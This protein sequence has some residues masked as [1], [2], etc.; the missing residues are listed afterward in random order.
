[1]DI[2]I[3][4]ENI[5]ACPRYAGVLIKGLTVTERPELLQNKLRLI[6][7]RPDNDILDLTNYFLHAKRS[8]LQRFDY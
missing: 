8:T 1:M 5:E 7:A 6:G 3:E 2:A 4:V